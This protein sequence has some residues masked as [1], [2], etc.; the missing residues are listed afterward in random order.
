LARE[1]CKKKRKRKAQGLENSR[2]PGR[3]LKKERRNNTEKETAIAIKRGESLRGGESRFEK[4]A[5]RMGYRARQNIFTKGKGEG[6]LGGKDKGGNREMWVL[7]DDK[8]LLRRKAQEGL[9]R[10]TRQRGR[11]RG[12]PLDEGKGGRRRGRSKLNLAEGGKKK[13]F[14]EVRP[15]R[16]K[17]IRARKDKGGAKGKRK[18]KWQACKVDSNFSQ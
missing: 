10:R 1:I 9:Q 6:G 4:I 5:S 8:L 3:T 17:K 16:K 11:D 12:T 7:T 13:N 18:K 14:C 2:V 15:L